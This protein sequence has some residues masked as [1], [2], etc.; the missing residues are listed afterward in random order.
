MR[1]AALIPARGGSKGIPLKNLRK[2]A[3]VRLL[4][5]SIQAAQAC[6][7]ISDV[8]VSTDCPELSHVA[9][10]AGAKVI[11]RPEAI[12]TDQASSESAIHHALLEIQKI[13]DLHDCIAFLQCT[14]PFTTSDEIRDVL[15]PIISG[16]ADSAFLAK[17]AHGFLWQ[18]SEGG[19]YHGVNHNHLLTRV[20]RQDLAPEFIETGAIYGFRAN[21]FLNLKNRFIGK[22]VAIE[23]RSIHADIDT[24]ED[25]MEAQRA[26]VQLSGATVSHF[27]P[28]ALITDFDGVHTN[29]KVNIAQDG[30]ESVVCNRRDGM[31]IEAAKK[32][33]LQVL[34]LS[35]E[36]NPVVEARAQK[37]GVEC[38]HG[39]DDKLTILSKWLKSKDLHWDDI[40][41][42]GDDV[43]D[44]DCL[45]LAG[46]SICPADAVTIVK[47]H[48]D[49]QLKTR[50]GEGCVREIIEHFQL[51]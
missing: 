35:K 32:K 20:R 21:D 43:N 16:K 45:Q 23:G 2:I 36:K 9:T 4:V 31:G 15:T 42:V 46:L 14:S 34:I 39:C 22:I 18:E 26:C 12:S 49:I 30:S 28:K 51:I 29:G 19:S 11:L 40:A 8:F 24:F 17:R 47:D 25:L 6:E 1:C 38:I 7:L 50:G 5:R 13:G 37:L 41:Y 48:S 3:G 33:G 10:R 44:L 27:I